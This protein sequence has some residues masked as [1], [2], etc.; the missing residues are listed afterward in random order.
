MCLQKASK[1]LFSIEIDSILTY[2]KDFQF[3]FIREGGFPPLLSPR[4][5]FPG[6]AEQDQSVVIYVLHLSLCKLCSK[7]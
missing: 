6:A 5:E 7:M 2:E 1:M 4:G 3:V